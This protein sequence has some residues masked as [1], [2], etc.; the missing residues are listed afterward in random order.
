MLGLHHD[1]G[2]R[3]WAVWPNPLASGYVPQQAIK[4][5]G[6]RRHIW[7]LSDLLFSWPSDLLGIASMAS[8]PLVPWTQEGP[9]ASYRSPNPLLS[10]PSGS[11]PTKLPLFSASYCPRPSEFSLSNHSSHKNKS[12]LFQSSKRPIELFLANFL[13][14][15]VVNSLM[16]G[17][18]VVFLLRENKLLQ[19]FKETKNIHS[20]NYIYYFI[21]IHL[22]FL[23]WSG[24]FY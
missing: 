2:G 15:A 13:Q 23:F 6:R 12:S 21:P 7:F 20:L 24:P 3:S 9:D 5:A 22:T 4:W 14:L 10:F 19:A 1:I 16:S 18:C 17:F 11:G 8:P